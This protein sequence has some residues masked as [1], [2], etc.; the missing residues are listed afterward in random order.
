MIKVGYIIPNK[1]YA[2]QYTST[3][4]IKIMIKKRY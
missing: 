3:Y 4:N 1:E 2:K